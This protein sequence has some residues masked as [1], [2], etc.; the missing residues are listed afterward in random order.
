MKRVV[1]L[2]FFLISLHSK[3]QGEKGAIDFG[4][5]GIV[6]IGVQEELGFD[7]KFAFQPNEQPFDILTGYSRYFV[8]QLQNQKVFNQLEIAFNY[9][10]YAY[11][12]L[13]FSVG[14]GYLLNDYE[15]L[16]GARDTSDLFVSSGNFNHGMLLKFR[17]E[18]YTLGN[19]I[20]FTEATIKSYG[21][22]YDTIGVG[23][24]YRIAI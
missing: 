17:A 9:D 12:P 19:I 23:L 2:L 14:M 18:Y 16:R 10:V 7:L 21:R 24:F 20:F 13:V 11:E 6:S 3:A 5:G 1:L 8:K 4:I 15:L 22:R